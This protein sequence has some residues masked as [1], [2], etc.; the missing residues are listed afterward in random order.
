MEYDT[1]PVLLRRFSDPL[2]V[3]N[4]VSFSSNA[5]AHVADQEIRTAD[6]SAHVCMCVSTRDHELNRAPHIVTLVSDVLV[7]AGG[8]GGHILL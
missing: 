8:G 2:R 4:V 1:G 3:F 6:V 7:T 5:A